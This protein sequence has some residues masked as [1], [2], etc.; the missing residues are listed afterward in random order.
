MT[1]LPLPLVA[2]AAGPVAALGQ[3]PWSLWW[4]ALVGYALGLGAVGAARRPILAAWLFGVGHFLV[5]LIWLLEP[6]RVDPMLTGWMAWPALALAA[7]GFALFWAAAGVGARWPGGAVGAGLGLAAGELARAYVLTGFPWALPGHVLIESPALPAASWLGGQGMTLAVCLGAG[8]LACLRPVATGAGVAVLAAPVALGLALSPAPAAPDGAPVVRLV[9]PNAPQHLKWHP[10][11]R[12][13]FFRRSLD[14]SAAPGDPA[15]VVW[16]E[17]A[18]PDLLRRT[19]AAR[20]R[21]AEAAGGAALLVGGQRIDR[22][23]AP[24]NSVVL[25]EGGTGAILDTHDKHRLVPFGEYLPLPRVAAALGLGP[26][27]AQLAGVFA[28]GPGPRL[29]DTPIGPVLPLICYEA[30]FPQDMGRVARPRVLIH[31]TND[32]WFGTRVGPRQH[33]ALARLRAAE[34]GLP[35]L[36]AANT[37]ISAAI[38]ARGRVLDSLGM[39]EAGALDAPLP[40]ALPPTFYARTGD[41]VAALALLALIALAGALRPVA[42]APR[43]G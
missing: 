1:R 25:L 21:M 31:Q 2:A 38:D 43:A 10:D 16:P 8:L 28:P 3:A 7:M 32:A 41:A 34:Q 26:L 37:G 4:L 27:A 14:L 20:A 5:A 17:T 35:V 42:P 19:G 36:R 6:F 24:R 9:Q 22:T 30:I 39:S 11:W 15:L 23:G 12:P 18:M 29:L 13:I 33:L 40:P